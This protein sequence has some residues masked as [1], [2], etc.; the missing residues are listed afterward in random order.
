MPERTSRNARIR[1][2]NRC[3]TSVVKARI[4]RDFSGLGG[5]KVAAAEFPYFHNPLHFNAKYAFIE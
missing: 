2:R 3:F 5:L 4:F 1:G